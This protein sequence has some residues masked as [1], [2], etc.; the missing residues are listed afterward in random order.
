MLT[1]TGYRNG[2]P[3]EIQLSYV[4]KTARGLDA[5]LAPDAAADFAR[6]AAACKEATGHDLIINE[7]YRS[8]EKQRRIYELWEAVEFRW[9]RAP[10]SARGPRPLRPAKPGYSKH[11]YGKALD[12]D[13]IDDHGRPRPYAQWVVQNHERFGFKR[14][15]PGEDWHFEHVGEQACS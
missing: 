2:Q 6:M 1:V 5:Y 14:T 13:L 4:G 3:L 12:L 10:E 9:L 15:V 7:A 11:G 8:L